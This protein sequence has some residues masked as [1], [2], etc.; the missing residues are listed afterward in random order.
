VDI[1]AWVVDAYREQ[2]DAGN[3]RLA[4]LIFEVPRLVSDLEHAEVDAVVPEALAL[5]R[6][7]RSPWLEVYFR[8]W[9]L[10]SRVIHRHAVKDALPDAVALL[11]FANRP[12]TKDCPQSVCVVQDIACTYADTDGPGY[13]E[14]RLAVSKEALGRID[15]TWPCWDCISGEHG[16]ALEDGGDA[17]GLLVFVEEQIRAVQRAGATVGHNL[18][19]RRATALLLL[20]RPAEAMAQSLAIEAQRD[21]HVITIRRNILLSRCHEALGELEQAVAQLP[22]P[23][24]VIGSAGYYAQWLE[25]AVP[26]VRHGVLENDGMFGQLVGR[27]GQELAD[28][29]SLF[30]SGRVY[31]YGAQL[32]VWRGARAVAAR[33]V[34]RA[35]A[36]LATLRRP[37]RPA[38]HLD[39]VRAQLAAMEPAAALEASSAAEVLEALGTDAEADLERLEAGLA[40]WPDEG[41]LVEAMAGALLAVGLTDDAIAALE[42]WRAAHEGD[43]QAFR[44][45]GELMADCGRSAQVTALIEEGLSS[46][47]HRGDALRLQAT[48]LLRGRDLRGARDVL[49]SLIDGA[50]P[51][52]GVLLDDLFRLARCHRQLGEPERAMEHLEPLMAALPPGHVEWEVMLSGTLLERWPVVR[53][54]AARIGFELD[55]EGPI[56]LP[57]ELCIV[58]YGASEGGHDA[59]AVRTGPVTARVLGVAGP[60]A[61]RET[62]GDRVLVD[63]APLGP[64]IEREDHPVYTFAAAS[65]LE[66]GGFRSFLLDGL[67]PSDSEYERLVELVDSH[68]GEVRDLTPESY[69]FMRD[70]EAHRGFLGALVVPSSLPVTRLYVPLRTLCATFERPLIWPGFATEAGDHGLAAEQRRS[71]APWGG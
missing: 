10:Q 19:A 53:E 17:E 61:A 67:R 40:R 65:V 5:A 7:A 22:E 4:Q 28:N 23:S 12:A 26:L 66:P 30:S 20:G 54:A 50:G 33:L 39:P 60:D 49:Q 1:W 6:G 21:N 45:L 8:H 9:H 46:D 24:A 70:G 35:E 57:G 25:A 48:L 32:A 27:M 55:G 38:L 11:D 64:A 59:L 37:D 51:G 16:A 44:F 36:R 13:V 68:G 52:E 3:G 42:G 34:A 43:P 71:M 62:Y 63:P 58:R 15:P 56:E 41:R 69:D 29:G 18:K 2:R 31:V 14:E 47:A